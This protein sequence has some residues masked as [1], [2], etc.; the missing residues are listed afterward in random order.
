MGYLKTGRLP[1]WVKVLLK[2]RF[3]KFKTPSGIDYKGFKVTIP[4]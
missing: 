2:I 4:W 3:G 1:W